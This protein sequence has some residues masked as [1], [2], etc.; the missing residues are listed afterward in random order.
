MLLPAFLH[1]GRQRAEVG[2]GQQNL[3]LEVD[4]IFSDFLRGE[5]DS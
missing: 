1:E 3:D 4:V 2:L 5:G